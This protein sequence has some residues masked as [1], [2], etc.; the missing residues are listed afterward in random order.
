[1]EKVENNEE[2]KATKVAE[3]LAAEKTAFGSLSDDDPS[4]EN[5]AT[6]KAFKNS[7]KNSMMRRITLQI[8]R[9]ICSIKL[10]IALLL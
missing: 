8:K 1:M 6:F 7:S 2:E 4:K 10:I 9:W 3:K 5:K